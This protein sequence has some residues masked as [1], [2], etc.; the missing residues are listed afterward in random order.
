LQKKMKPSFI[1]E[2]PTGRWENQDEKRF[3]CEARSFRW[4]NIDNKSMT[5]SKCQR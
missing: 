5:A 4:N 1:L 3:A 2:F